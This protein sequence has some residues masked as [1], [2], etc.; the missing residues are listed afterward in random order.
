[1]RI[2]T[3][4]GALV[5]AAPVLAAPAAPAS[6]AQRGTR[7]DHFLECSASWDLGRIKA[8]A[9][10]CIEWATEVEAAP[11]AYDGW[12]AVLLGWLSAWRRAESDSRAR[13]TL[14][15]C[16]RLQSQVR[17]LQLDDSKCI[18]LASLTT[19]WHTSTRPLP[20]DVDSAHRGRL[21]AVKRQRG[22]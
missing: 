18:R 20:S 8:C 12:A 2:T 9:A 16:Q 6:P 10:E 14:S 3:L 1:M 22:L 5:L 19:Q 11:P 21:D 4:L 15:V 17:R 13:E 7:P